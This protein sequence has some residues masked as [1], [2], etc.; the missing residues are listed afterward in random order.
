MARASESAWVMNV[1]QRRKVMSP[2]VDRCVGLAA[3]LTGLATGC[4]SLAQEPAL[5]DRLVV[6][7]W[8]TFTSLH[9]EHG[10]AV[11][12]IN[13]DDEP[14]PNF[15]HRISGNLLL[16]P[17]FSA[18]SIWAK[19]APRCHPDVTMRLETPV[20]YFHPPQGAKSP[21]TLDVEVALRG[22]WLSEYY[23]DAEV[24]AP[25]VN[26]AQSFGR[27]STDVVGR[28]RWE[29][30]AVGVDAPGPETTDPVWVAPRDVDAASVTSSGGESERFLFYR[31]VGR[32]ESPLRVSR[33]ATWQ[34]LVIT[35]EFP[36]VEQ[37]RET[38]LAVPALWL[39]DV[40]DDKSMASRELEGF[41]VTNDGN[42]RV[43]A[44]TPAKFDDDQY[45]VDNVAELGLEMRTA[46]I[47]DGLFADEAD[48]LIETWKAAY[49]KSPGLRLFYL[50]PQAWTDHVMP[51]KLSTDAELV[52]T[53][54]G[55]VEIV[56]PKQRVLLRKIAAGPASNLNWLLE[57]SRV[58]A[59][60]ETAEPAD[61]SAY[62]DLGRFRN[63]LVLDELK[64][65]P[66]AA[67][68]AFVDGY[69]LGGYV[70][71]E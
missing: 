11:G 64:Q 49:F 19:S 6:H 14:V 30:L 22:G 32:I 21:M 35:A 40:R 8:G 5:S 67:L 17:G 3:L 46:L 20:V 54:V 42:S 27:L 71:A 2:I 43:V 56:S 23:P 51:M 26:G 25:G 4:V 28:L 52:R 13:S 45:H 50:L 1:A 48:A 66:T 69:R 15:V 12:G 58:D 36:V 39:V 55:R 53:M 38:E 18:P 62:R 24:E 59:T 57:A 65:R 68:R 44:R 7:E 31:G 61:Y 41:R 37:S 10:A 34:S 29:D 9:D 60:T 47:E 33:D 63:A 70:P 16:R